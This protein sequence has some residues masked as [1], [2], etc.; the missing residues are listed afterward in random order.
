MLLVFALLLM[1]MWLP[2]EEC[3]LQPAHAAQGR[4]RQTVASTTSLVD[5][6][7]LQYG[8]GVHLCASYVF[9]RAAWVYCC[10]GATVQTWK[11]LGKYL[12]L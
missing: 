9:G 6:A 8:W 4:I 1:I 3:I 10:E 12:S 11:F 2:A 5:I 7:Y